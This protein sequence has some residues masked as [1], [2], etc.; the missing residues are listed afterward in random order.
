[1]KV[2]HAAVLGALATLTAVEDAAAQS[3][4]N[5]VAGVS[6]CVASDNLW[7]SANGD[8]TWVAP[9]TST[10]ADSVALGA[11][12]TWIHRPI[13]LNVPSAA[14]NGTNVYVVE[15][16][17]QVHL[18]TSIGLHR[19]VSFDVAAPFIVHQTGAGTGFLTGAANELPRSA[20]GEL[21]LGPT[22]ALY[23]RRSF[24]LAGRLQVLAPTGSPYGFSRFDSVTLAPGLSAAFHRNRLRLGADVGARLRKAVELGN[25]I[26]GHQLSFGVAGSYD[27]LP[28]SWLSVGAEA[29]ALVGL[30]RQYVLGPNAAGEDTTG[31]PIVPAEWLLSFS[32]GRMLGGK[33]R[34]RVGVGGGIPIPGTSDVTA[35]S[36]RT[37]A[38]LSFTP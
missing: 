15:D 4:C 3:P 5:T 22:V 7:P 6:S 16:A 34:A 23:H 37:V 14:P 33:V 2:V 17:V 24:D 21:R 11:T 19:R 35:P 36:L 28:R 27:L 30:E 31:R 13:G 29:F 38:S 32:S 1:M 25:A 20:V 26:I 12:T 8:F 18:V 9:A 10:P